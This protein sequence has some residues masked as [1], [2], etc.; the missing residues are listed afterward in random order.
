MTS[1]AA[2]TPSSSV[3]EPDRVDIGTGSDG[4]TVIVEVP[5]D[6]G[7]V[8]FGT[9]RVVVVTVDDVVHVVE[10]AAGAVVVRIGGAVIVVRIAGTV[11]TRVGSGRI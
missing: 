1:L 4:G 5:V 11:V 10:L 9:V 7:L 3:D 2:T 6:P 8:V